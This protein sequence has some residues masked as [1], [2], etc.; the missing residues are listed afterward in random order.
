M[1]AGEIN[2]VGLPGSEVYNDSNNVG[3]S[4]A[5]E[6]GGLL[7]GRL[8]QNVRLLLC[9]LLKRLDCLVDLL[10]IS[11]FS[12]RQLSQAFCSLSKSIGEIVK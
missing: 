10:Y 9:F 1:K 2:T 6:D 8:F 5:R 3:Q 4:D 12:P 7:K 11:S